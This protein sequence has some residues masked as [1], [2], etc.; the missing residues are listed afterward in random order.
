MNQQ[1]R[2]VLLILFAVLLALLVHL[3]LIVPAAVKN[4]IANVTRAS[5]AL[6]DLATAKQQPTASSTPPAPK[7]IPQQPDIPKKDSAQATKIKVIKEE[8]LPHKARKY[9]IGHVAN[10][11]AKPLDK[12]ADKIGNEAE[13]TTT[14]RM[15]VVDSSGPQ[16]D[17]TKPLDQGSATQ[18]LGSEI[19]RGYKNAAQ[20]EPVDTHT[21]DAESPDIAQQSKISNQIP[22]ANA[23]VPQR[24]EKA[25]KGAKSEEAPIK[26]KKKRKSGGPTGSHLPYGVPVNGNGPTG[27]LNNHSIFSQENFYA[28]MARMEGA[29]DNDRVHAQ[30]DMRFTSYTNR[31]GRAIR[32]SIDALIIEKPYYKPHLTRFGRER[33]KVSVEFT[34]L[35]TGK[36]K[37]V[38]ILK[39][40]G[41]QEV[42]QYIK[43]A[44]YALSDTL[45]PFPKWMNF[46]FIKLPTGMTADPDDQASYIPSFGAVDAG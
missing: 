17:I 39:S 28:T 5:Q 4:I 44:I 12:D 26:K 8:D 2:R 43:E 31:I 3:C 6:V 14:P 18:K 11:S 37:D 33:R 1:R 40:S 36:I 13:V 15:P 22:N 9:L 46:D 27:K 24:T 35:K 29:A 19:E 34:V 38:I 7:E 41:I 23:R 10:P 45:P 32:T 20:Q 30:G 21:Q 42:D 25:L 16:A